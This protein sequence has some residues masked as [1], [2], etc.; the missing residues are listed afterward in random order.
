MNQPVRTL[1]RL[2]QEK[3]VAGVCA[4]LAYAHEAGVSHHDVQPWLLLVDDAGHVQV[5]GLAAG[6]PP[7]PEG[8]R[9]PGTFDSSTLRSQRQA[10][11]RDLL[12]LGLVLHN[13][14]GGGVA[15]DEPDVG[16]VIDRMPPL[17][18]EVVRLG[19][20]FILNITHVTGHTCITS[21]HACIADRYAI[22]GGHGTG[23]SRLL[24]LRPI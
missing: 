10:A 14:L 3:K 13:A 7:S 15:L 22:P 16:R 17:G 21:G 2:P 8:E 5:A 9:E 6:A 1:R 11:E 12:A 19:W 23:A 4:G 18:R 20:S 24:S